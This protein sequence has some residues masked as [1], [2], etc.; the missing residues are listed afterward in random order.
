MHCIDILSIFA[1]KILPTL[2]SV[3]NKLQINEIIFD[4]AKKIYKVALIES[5]RNMPVGD[6]LTFTL[7]GANAET[8]IASLRAARGRISNAAE[9]S[10]T[11][12]DN[13][14]RAIVTRHAV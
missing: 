3:I 9:Y 6:S 5:L 4:M 13:G 8:D 14:L 11:T 2:L 12:T 1:A 10:I 7:S